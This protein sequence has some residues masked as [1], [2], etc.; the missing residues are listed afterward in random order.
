[1]S[2]IEAAE[3]RESL[4]PSGVRTVADLARQLVLLR[5]TTPRASVADDPLTL[6]ELSDI[7][8]VPRSTLGNAES[9]RILPRA[10][11]VYKFA[12]GCQERRSRLDRWVDAR[13]RVA[14]QRR[15]EPDH[16]A[17]TAIAERIAEP[18][19]AG[20]VQV[21]V[22]F[23]RARGMPVTVADFDK[24]LDAMPAD[25]CAEHLTAMPPEAAAECLHAMA[26]PRAT[27]CLELL[28]TTVAAA[29]LCD[30]DPAMAAEHLQ[31]LP[32]SATRQVLPVMPIPAV[33]Q[34]LQL[35]P[36][37]A[38]ETLVATM[39]AD[40]T[41]ALIADD[42]VPVFLAADLFFT[43]GHRRSL[44]L[45]G[46]LRTTRLAGLLAAMNPDG[47]AGILASLPEPRRWSVLAAMSEVRAARILPHLSDEHFALL[48]S[49]V[50][51]GEAAGLLA[52]TPPSWAAG[53]L[54]RL[55]RDERSAILAAVP[56]Q[57]RNSIEANINPA[58]RELPPYGPLTPA[59]RLRSARAD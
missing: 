1:M 59:W 52:E 47:A 11:V 58:L 53:V 45:A 57:R 18:E 14:R 21:A 25:R 40:W 34:R 31:L 30:E 19:D 29:M 33:A 32:V 54:A 12:A 37:H 28:E 56:E 49:G 15:R 55:S 39:P 51:A 38:A 42:A 16:P 24:A 20:P 17:I 13:N 48:L 9:G 10:Q 5:L 50:S 26:A 2:T 6:R 43:V 36:R 41:V 44:G 7:T 4:D 27:A 35:M 8:G 22:R 3:L 46:T 23:L